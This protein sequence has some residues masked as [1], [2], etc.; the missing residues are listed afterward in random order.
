MEESMKTKPQVF[1][2]YAS[3]D[4]EQVKKIY[5]GLV[6]RSVNVWFDK[7]NLGL[8]LWKPQIEKAIAQSRYSV[9]CVSHHALRKTGNEAASGSRT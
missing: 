7:V 6:A 2:S 5:G 9:I 8:G 3:E 4:L 1:L